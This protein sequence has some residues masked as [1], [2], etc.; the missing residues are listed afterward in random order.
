MSRGCVSGKSSFSLSLAFSPESSSSVISSVTGFFFI[1]KKYL[2]QI[3]VFLYQNI[4]NKK[5]TIRRVQSRHKWNCQ[6]KNFVFSVLLKKK[7][8]KP[9]KTFLNS[10]QN[11]ITF[12]SPSCLQAQIF[13]SASFRESL[14]V[15]GISS[16][17]DK[18][19]FTSNSTFSTKKR[20]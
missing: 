10:Q 11:K 13:S 18:I 12:L 4:F 3:Q 9:N 16:Q 8:L 15:L 17:L 6:L 7:F 1:P 5:I 19:R 2:F 14:S 20:N